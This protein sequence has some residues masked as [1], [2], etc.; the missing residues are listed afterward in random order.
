MP[1]WQECLECVMEEL[2]KFTAA[3]LEESGY[4][5]RITAPLT[6]RTSRTNSAC[7]SAAGTGPVRKTLEMTDIPG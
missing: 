4:G 3:A 2:I 7:Q 6:H 1:L 5:D